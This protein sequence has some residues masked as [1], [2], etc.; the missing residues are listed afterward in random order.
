[1]RLALHRAL[2]SQDPQ[3]L[4]AAKSSAPHSPAITVQDA[5]GWLTAAWLSGGSDKEADQEALLVLTGHGH[6]QLLSFSTRCAQPHFCVLILCSSFSQPQL[7]LTLQPTQCSVAAYTKLCRQGRQ[8]I[9]QRQFTWQL[10]HPVTAVVPLQP[11]D[12]GQTQL[13]CLLHTPS[14]MNQLCSP[15][16]CV[17]RSARCLT[18][19]S[20][21][22][23]DKLRPCAVQQV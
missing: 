22:H 14:C 21:R 19:L 8:A 2:H 6:V 20:C 15:C 18:W 11:D 16:V 3:T 4:P 7:L 23:S 12:A 1:M 17:C 13:H 10:D 5:P 9:V